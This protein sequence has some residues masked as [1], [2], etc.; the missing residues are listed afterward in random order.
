VVCSAMA[1]H[2]VSIFFWHDS[3]LFQKVARGVCAIHL[4]AFAG[5]AMLV[6][7]AHVVEHAAAIQQLRIKLQ[8]TM[9]ACQG[10]EVVHAAGMME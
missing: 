2:T 3:M 7:Q 1:V 4:E 5:A 6:G 9:F 8:R 10:P